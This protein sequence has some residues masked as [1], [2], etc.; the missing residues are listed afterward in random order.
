MAGSAA[1]FPAGERRRA[2]GAA[3][4]GAKPARLPREFRKTFTGQETIPEKPAR[5][6]ERDERLPPLDLLETGDSA[7]VTSREINQT[8]GLIEKTLADF[9]IPAK[10]V[11]FRTG[12]TVTQFA[13]EPGFIEH[14]GAG[15][16]APQ[17]EGARLA[18]LGPGERPGAGALRAR[19]L[20]IEAP[21]PGRPTSAS[22]CPTAGRR[23]V[24]LR[25][26][27]GVGG[28]PDDRLAAGDRPGARRR[29]RGRRRRPGAHAAPA[30][31]RH[32][33]LGQVGVHHGR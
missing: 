21:V 26:D 7:R 24:R 17:A 14:P 18:D 3:P 25:S 29:R 4:A 11:D 23:M 15:R 19:P 22:R 8:A 10:V 30:D 28:L 6:A 33:R 32:D 31:R 20:R 13:V 27:P 1:A 9:G 2:S 16:G 12:P 5:P